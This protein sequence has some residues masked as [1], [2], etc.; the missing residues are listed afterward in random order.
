MTSLGLAI[1]D[2]WETGSR[3]VLVTMRLLE[4]CI[5]AYLW[6]LLVFEADTRE[7]MRRNCALSANMSHDLTFGKN[8]YLFWLE[9]HAACLLVTVLPFSNTAGHYFSKSPI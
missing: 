8:C 7:K 1:W 2:V 6:L 9:W 3:T 5:V 4:S